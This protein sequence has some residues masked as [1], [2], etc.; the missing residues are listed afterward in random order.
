MTLH[1]RVG[2][3]GPAGRVGLMGDCE[4]GARRGALCPA[5]PPAPISAA[6]TLAFRAPTPVLLLFGYTLSPCAIVG[7]FLSRALPA[8][9]CSFLY[10]VSMKTIF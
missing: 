2:V 5:C 8:N 6:V 4:E 7:D 9:S 3:S 10:F 1:G